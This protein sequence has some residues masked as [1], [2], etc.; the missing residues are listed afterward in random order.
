MGELYVFR[1][2][3]FE[4]AIHFDPSRKDFPQSGN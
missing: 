2:D 3:E 4:N 1:Y